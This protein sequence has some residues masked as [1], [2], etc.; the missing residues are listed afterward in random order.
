[1]STERQ[2][3]LHLPRSGSDFADLRKAVFQLE[4]ALAAL[5]DARANGDAE[6]IQIAQVRVTEAQAKLAGRKGEP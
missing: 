2:L 1:M 6:E 5:A 3:D 4:A